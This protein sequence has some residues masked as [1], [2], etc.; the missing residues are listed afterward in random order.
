MHLWLTQAQLLIQ[1]EMCL[2]NSQFPQCQ[3]MECKTLRG[4]THILRKR[5]TWLSEN[6]ACLCRETF[7]AG[8]SSEMY[9]PHP[10]LLKKRCSG[11]SQ[12][13][14]KGKRLQELPV[15]KW[16]LPAVALPTPG[17]SRGAP[18]SSPGYYS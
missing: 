3:T 10:L 1:Q 11:T 17:S 4:N 2:G 14:I 6:V 18:A 15:N 5:T 13:M 12:S 8:K 16:V 9:L 7:L